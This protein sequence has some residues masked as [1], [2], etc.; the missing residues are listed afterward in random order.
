MHKV[1]SLKFCYVNAKI[2]PWRVI[3][4]DLFLKF[5]LFE[6][7]LISRSIKHRN[8]DKLQW[9]LMC[10]LS[11]VSVYKFSEIQLNYLKYYFS[12]YRVNTRSKSTNMNTP[13]GYYTTQLK[14]KPKYRYQKASKFHATQ[15]EVS[16]IMFSELI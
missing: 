15:S 12:V 6:N 4:Q 5:L 2:L 8:N 16:K 10:V 9:L 14:E 11:N 3:N 1:S 7:G 13:D